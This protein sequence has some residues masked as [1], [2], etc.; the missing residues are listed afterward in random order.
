MKLNQASLLL[1]VLLLPLSTLWLRAATSDQPTT[2]AQ[3][4]QMETVKRQELIFSANQAIS[5]GQRLLG[6]AKYDEAA[7][8]FQYAL[9]ALTPGGVSATS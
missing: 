5:D 2:A 1:A 7:A 6:S 3:A 9:D 4:A 8:R